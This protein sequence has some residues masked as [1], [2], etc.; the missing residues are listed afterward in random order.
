MLQV[1]KIHILT[2][3]INTAFSG[4]AQLESI[5][6]ISGVCQHLQKGVAVF[7]FARNGAHLN[8]YVFCQTEVKTFYRKMK[9]PLEGIVILNNSKSINPVHAGI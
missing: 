4:V 2:L 8:R 6:L 3:P 5:E 1:K 9:I 7:C